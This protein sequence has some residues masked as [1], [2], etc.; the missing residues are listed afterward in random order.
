MPHAWQAPEGQV[1]K[2]ARDVPDMPVPTACWASWTVQSQIGQG[3]TAQIQP[4]KRIRAALHSEPELHR[5]VAMASLTPNARQ[6][7]PHPRGS[8]PEA[9][10]ATHTSGS[11]LGRSRI[12]AC[13]HT[14]ENK[15]LNGIAQTA[16][17]KR[18]KYSPWDVSQENH[19]MLQQS[20]LA[21]HAAV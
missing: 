20:V 17:G 16:Y 8:R 15:N 19:L 3:I 12:C 6:Q 5:R 13:T 4:C 2:Q 9:L 11:G 21:H 14:H 1:Q 7:R 18:F 10:G